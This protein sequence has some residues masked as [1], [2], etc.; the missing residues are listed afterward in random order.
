MAVDNE[1]YA[2]MVEMRKVNI[3]W[4]RC[5]V[6]DGT[7]VT[8]CLKCRGYNH[9]AKECKNQEICLRCHGQHKT[10]DCKNKEQIMKCINCM[11][12]NKKN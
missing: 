11:K 5:R 3:G 10:K 4:E 1:S 9:I 7:D 12:I 2:K 8:Q 6:F